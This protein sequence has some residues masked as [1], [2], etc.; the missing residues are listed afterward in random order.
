M[1]GRC[2]GGCLARRRSEGAPGFVRRATTTQ[3]GAAWA[4][5]TRDLRYTTLE[6]ET[7]HG[8]VAK[9]PALLLEGEQVASHA[10]VVRPLLDRVGPLES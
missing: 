6:F 2:P 5:E 8:S 4:P 7:A 9:L 1:D 3:P 10:V